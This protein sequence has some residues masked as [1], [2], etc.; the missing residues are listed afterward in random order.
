MSRSDLLALQRER[1][2][3]GLCSAHGETK[4]CERCAEAMRKRKAGMARS[5]ESRKAQKAARKA[6][7]K[8]DAKPEPSVSQIETRAMLHALHQARAQWVY[9]GTVGAFT[10]WLTE[11]IQALER[12]A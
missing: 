8:P 11:Q 10:R 9:L 1:R 7:S 4:P 5:H 6:A 2:A 3:A 12:R